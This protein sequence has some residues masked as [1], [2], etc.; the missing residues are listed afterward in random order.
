MN[1]LDKSIFGK[2]YR[3]VSEDIYFDLLKE[4]VELYPD[5]QTTNIDVNVFITSKM[6]P[7]RSNSQNPKSHQTTDDGMNTQIGPH[8]IAWSRTD[9]GVLKSALEYKRPKYIITQLHKYAG[10][11]C[12]T[13]VE[14]FEQ[15]L[16]ELILVPSIYFFED[17]VPVHSAAIKIGSKSII[18]A[19]TGGVGKSSALLALRNTSS[20]SFV[21]DDIS[22]VDGNGTIYGNM[23]WPKIYGYNCKGTDFTKTLLKNRG[24]L[25]RLH[26]LIRNKINS[27][28]VRRKLRPDILY[29]EVHASSSS[30]NTFY[31]L[32]REDV[33]KFSVS[34]LSIDEAVSMSIAVM[35]TEYAVFH[36]H[37]YWE[38]YNSL[39]SKSKPMICMNDIVRN[40][41]KTLTT[42]LQNLEVKKISIPLNCTHEAYLNE[43]QLW[44]K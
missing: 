44:A 25:D 23:A 3:F 26:F 18:F 24:L 32:F 6:N 17:R 11:E 42:A 4:S 33:S 20:S 2:N 7:S 21:S 29:Q 14:I 38:E 9:N 1:Q 22:I 31:Y 36:N 37:I 30:C 40:W 12:A 19:G 5:A 28:T 35:L 39:G 43:V 8:R 27:T 41:R 16:H 15:I 13:E 34:D 10:K